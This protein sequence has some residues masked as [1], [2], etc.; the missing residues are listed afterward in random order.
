MSV[1][2]SFLLITFVINIIM[3]A[4]WCVKERAAPGRAR[5]ANRGV[6]GFSV[7]GRVANPDPTVILP[8]VPS[9]YGT[10]I[11]VLGI[12]HIVLAAI[13]VVQHIL[14]EP[15]EPIEPVTS[16]AGLLQFIPRFDVTG[17]HAHRPA[18]PFP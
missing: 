11:I 12:I 5:A 3:L 18:P 4:T 1:H 7:E 6:G 14:N 16:P 17:A 9:W 10:T 13:V 15:F 2:Y 8:I